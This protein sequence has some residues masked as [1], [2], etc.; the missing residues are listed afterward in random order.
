[1]KEKDWKLL[2]K[3][4]SLNAVD[5]QKVDTLLGLAESEECKKLLKIQ[6]THLY[7]REEFLA[8]LL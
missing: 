2:Q 8:D 1:M 7:R 6:Q 3:A 5:H 4:H